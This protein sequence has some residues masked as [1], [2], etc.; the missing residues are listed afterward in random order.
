M[1]ESRDKQEVNGEVHVPVLNLEGGSIANPIPG[2]V[3]QQIGS[4]EHAQN[5]IVYRTILW[6]FA[7]GGL[8]SAAAI[9]ISFY[10]GGTSPL[11]DVKDVWSIL[12][13]LITLSLGYLFGKGR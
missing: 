1:T 6:S 10:Q 8:L 3:T 5:S 2:L 7:G 9:A 13:P 11:T 4:G 12:T